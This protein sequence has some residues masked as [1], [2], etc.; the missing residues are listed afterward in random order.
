MSLTL[1]L[2]LTVSSPSAKDPFDNLDFSRGSLKGWEG[3][4][5]YV[6]TL[7]RVGPELSCGVCSSDL[8]REDRTGILHRTIVLPRNAGVIRFRAYVQFGKDLEDA[9]DLD[10]K[11]LA[12][13]RQVVSKMVRGKDEWQPVKRVLP[14]LKGQPRDYIFPVSNYA[15]QPV[16][17]ALV[18][19]DKRPG[20]HL[21]CS[22]F[23]IQSSDDFDSREFGQFMVKLTKE[24]KL[25]APSRYESKHFVAMSTADD[26]FS[27]LRLHN[28]EL[29]YELFFDHFRRKGFRLRE[30][31]GKM[32][33][34]VFDTQAGFEAYLGHKMPTTVTGVYH[35]PSNRL[36]VYDYGSNESFV[37][38]KRTV[39]QA[40]R[41]IAADLDR[42]R[43]VETENRRAREFR[44]GVNIGTVM[45]EVAHQLS[46]NTGMMN[47]EGDI[48]IWLA[49]GLATYCEPTDNQIWQGIGESNPERLAALS[50]F[51]HG[52][53]RLIPLRDLVSADAWLR[54]AKEPGIILIGYA[55][56]WA[57]FRMLIEERPEQLRRFLT[58][59]YPRHGPEHRLADFGQA[60]GS[61]IERLEL[62]LGEYIKEAVERTY[63]PKR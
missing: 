4:G 15:G 38:F 57:L 44:T 12:S 61:D 19:D 11:V 18:D 27:E 58:L 29:I 17:I 63:R 40:S 23:R 30:P 59:V 10:V 55:Q 24:H 53:G 33:V 49:E 37:A 54:E 45:H 25:P 3:E 2:L 50:P 26:E 7:S 9:G 21:V 28:C 8:A 60:F 41:Q 42:Q 46:F 52:Q 20:C 47:R 13:G 35:L 1:A 48:P 62:R 56:S 39:Q 31:A 36:I 14:A 22:G 5:F 34:A 43:F 6:T 32:M 51:A 16:R